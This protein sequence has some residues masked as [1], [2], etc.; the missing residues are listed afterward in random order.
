MRLFRRRKEQGGAF[1]VKAIVETYSH[2]NC[3]MQNVFFYREVVPVRLT[4]RFF[5]FPKLIL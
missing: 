2:P 1:A 4:A 3:S 5:E